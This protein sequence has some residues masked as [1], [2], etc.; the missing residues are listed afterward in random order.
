MRQQGSPHDT[1]D[2]S[3]GR[4]EPQRVAQNV[5]HPLPP[6][7]IFTMLGR[8][9]FVTASESS[10]ERPSWGLEESSKGHQHR[11]GVHQEPAL[12]LLAQLSHKHR[13]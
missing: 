8:P 9:T 12:G 1:L 7:R 10:L 3:I 5:C 13:M 2:L 6:D 11:M 4:R